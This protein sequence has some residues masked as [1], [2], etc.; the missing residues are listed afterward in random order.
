MLLV[1]LHQ[2]HEALFWDD[3]AQLSRLRPHGDDFS[4]T[5]L[6]EAKVGL[7]FHKS[8][9]TSGSWVK[10]YLG[11]GGDPTDPPSINEVSYTEHVAFLV[12]WLCKFLACPKSGGI[13]KEFQALA[14]VLA[15]GHQVA[16]SPIFLAYLYR[17]LREVIT[18]PMD[19]HASDSIWIFQ[20]WLQLYFLEL[21]P[22]TVCPN[23][24]ALLGPPLLNA[25]RRKH[26]VENCFRFFYGCQERTREHLSICLD[27]LF[28]D[29]LALDLSSY[30]MAE[31]KEERHNMWANI[32][33]SRDLPYGLMMNKGSNYHCGGELYYPAAANYQ[34]GFIQRIPIPPMNFVNLLSSWWV[35][36]K[37]V[38]EVTTLTNF[39]QELV[40]SFSIPI[41]DPQFGDSNIFIHWW[42]EMS[43]SWF[44]Q[45]CSEIEDKVFRHCPCSLAFQ[46]EKE[47]KKAQ[48]KGSP[49]PMEHPSSSPLIGAVQSAT[50]LSAAPET[51]TSALEKE[52][53]A[54]II[55]PVGEDES[56]EINTTEHPE[57][58]STRSHEIIL[59]PDD[60]ASEHVAE[61]TKEDFPHVPDSQRA[62]F[63]PGLSLADTT[64]IEAEFQPLFAISSDSPLTCPLEAPQ[65]GSTFQADANITVDH[66]IVISGAPSTIPTNGSAPP[67]PVL[68]LTLGAP[69]LVD[70]VIPS[71]LQLEIGE[72]SSFV[73]A[74]STMNPSVE[75]ERSLAMVP[76][77]EAP[78]PSPDQW[79]ASISLFK[80]STR[81]A[82][83]S[84]I[85]GALPDSGAEALL[86]SYRDGDLMSMEDKDE[87][88]KLKATIEIVASFGFFSNPRS[89]AMITY[90]FGQVEKFA[91]HCRPFL[92]EQRM[93]Q[94]LEQQIT[95]C[96]ATMT[97]E[98]EIAH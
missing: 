7:D 73:P 58:V 46:Q 65:S 48:A 69:T 70:D 64:V 3:D 72:S 30:P 75:D 34:L 49:R 92:E 37:D 26:Y 77:E 71:E 20:L 79:D 60:H 43:A 50:T 83:F 19:Y 96:S 40:K 94:D 91:L 74:E 98:I 6:P 9:K 82:T 1:F 17:G 51:Q 15:D 84:T 85:T 68:M 87:R 62:I 25:P 16:M 12:M 28:Q 8:N 44:S 56:A 45:P 88:N 41:R 63:G 33:I 76:H 86:R 93:G 13:T 27:H 10:T 4:A 38:N 66:A 57:D 24:K 78:L 39:N 67:E 36:F 22:T 90:L 81:L 80:A 59:M 95:S 97:K 54:Q 53:G 2:S 35:E 11:Y 47:K 32:L 14:E 18:K 61:L 52:I 23:N 89:S 5:N 55:T 21:S 29:Y 31:T 42:K